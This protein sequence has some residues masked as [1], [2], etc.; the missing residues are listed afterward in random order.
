MEMKRSSFVC[1]G[2]PGGKDSLVYQEIPG[3]DGGEE[4][5]LFFAAG[6]PRQE[7][8]LRTMFREAVSASRLG[9]P[10]HYFARVMETF[11]RETRFAAESD[12]PLEKALLL[13]E[14]RRGD[15]VHFLCNRDATLVHWNGETGA[16]A[17]VESVPGLRELSLDAGRGQRDLFHRAPEDY[18]ALYRFETSGSH[19][20]ALV[21]SKDFAERHAETLRNSIFF[22]SFEIPRETGL[23]LPV[24][25]S[26]PVIHWRCG[27]QSGA[28]PAHV[29]AARIRAAAPRKGL[30]QRLPLA[31]GAAAGV[32]GIVSLLMFR[33]EGDRAAVDAGG[34]SL[35]AVDGPADT[36][37]GRANASE[38]PSRAGTGIR[39][40]AALSEAWNKSFRAPVTSSPR[41]EGGTVYFG[42][43]DGHLYAYGA[44]GELTW[45]YRASDGIGASPLVLDGRVVCADYR[46][47]LFCLDSATGT[48]LWKIALGSKVVSSP[49]GRGEAL[50]AAT[51]DGRIVGVAL[52]DGKRL[53]EKKIGVSMRATPAAGKNYVVAATT[54]GALVKLDSNGKVL[55]TAAVG[56]EIL[57][58]PLAIDEKELVVL[59]APNRSV[60][61]RSLATGK[62]VWKLAADSPVNG[63]PALDGDAIYVGARS[64]SVYA[65]G[66]DGAQRWRAGAGGA[67]LS[68][69]VVFGGSVFVTTYGSQLVA[70]DAAT[71]EAV[72][73]YRADSAIY[74]SPAIDG[75]R[76]YFGS[77]GGVFR[78][79]WLV[80]PA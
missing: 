29:A 59:G 4:F 9:S 13:I 18:F 63:S 19:T 64:G 1:L 48:L 3:R 35:V 73:R 34:S 77:N 11:G 61:A 33:G 55:W 6:D 8:L 53:W 60:E 7:S 21:P 25:R 68:K 58:S 32:I 71:G 27:A 46:G 24:E 26:F 52:R 5:F 56:G 42:C 62:V 10:L 72:G 23:A 47:Q 57:S 66:L 12:D 45:K 40:G 69:P 14:I 79:L 15:E 22:P 76:V 17:P 54:D 30:S 2:E 44:D 50:Y 67:V 75:V 51:T 70:F 74:S 31:V 43:R 80:P 41:V 78:A 16:P 38:A 20:L 49:A 65:I 36:A 28:R 39:A 37:K